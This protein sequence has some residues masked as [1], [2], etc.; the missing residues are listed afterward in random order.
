[1]RALAGEGVQTMLLEGGPTL[2][3]AFVEAGLVDKLLVFVAPALAGDGPTLTRSLPAPL[4]LKRLR[5]EPVGDDLLLEAYVH[6]P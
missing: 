4:Q 1:L 5:A 3:S 2:A 6:D